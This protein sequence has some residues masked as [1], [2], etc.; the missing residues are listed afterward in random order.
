[1]ACCA[2]WTDSSAGSSACAPRQQTLLCAFAMSRHVTAVEA[3]GKFAFADADATAR[4]RAMATTPT[5]RSAVT[6]VRAA[7]MSVFA[8]PS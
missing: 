8:E 4:R 3:G 6:R 2:R 5:A 7:V 1:M